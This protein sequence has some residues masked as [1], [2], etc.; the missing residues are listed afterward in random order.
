MQPFESAK[1]TEGVPLMSQAH[2]RMNQ[3]VSH[4][5][6]FASLGMGLLAS[7]LRY[8]SENP[9]VQIW[10]FL[11]WIASLMA[12]FG[13]SLENVEAFKIVTRRLAAMARIGMVIALLFLGIILFSAPLGLL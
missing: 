8:N 2:N 1:D 7:I 12:I 4:W 9:L 5:L 13:F 11:V 6:F 3:A 10:F